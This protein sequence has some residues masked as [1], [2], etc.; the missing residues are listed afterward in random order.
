MNLILLKDEDFISAQRAVVTGRRLAHLAKVLNAEPGQKMAC[1]RLNGN[2]GW[3]TL[4]SINSSTAELEVLLDTPPPPPLPLTLVL[5]LPRPKMLRR[6]IECV[7]SLGVKQIFLVNSWRVEKSFWQSPVLDDES[8]EKSMIL[9]LEQAGDTVMPVIR[10]KRIFTRFVKQELP[11][12]G[13]GCR[14]ITAHPKTDQSCPAG[15]NQKTVLAVGP[16]GGFID[17]EVKTLE[18]QG[19][20][21]CSLGP[22]ILRVETAVPFLISRLF[23]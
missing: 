18:E 19:F 23:H 6:V 21:S 4:V 8:L 5:A 11:G 17:L 12:I 1:G 7:T 22:R 15:V 9:G 3:A 2:R 10:K 16:E 13:D 14:C 20:I